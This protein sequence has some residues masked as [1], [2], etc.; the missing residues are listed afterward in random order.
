MNCPV[1]GTALVTEMYESTIEIDK[2]PTCSGIWLDKGELEE[3][4]EKIEN[5]YSEEIRSIPDDIAGAMAAGKS[6]I[7]KTYWCP[8]CGEDLEKAE[9]GLCSQ[10]FIDKCPKGHGIWLHKGELEQLEIF[11]ERSH[12]ETSDLEKGFFKTLLSLFTNK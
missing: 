11:F 7:E 6:R 8:K 5:D 12:L 2:C 10:I 3:I 4:Q 1:D 9:Y